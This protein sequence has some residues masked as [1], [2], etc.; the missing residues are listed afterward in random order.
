MNALFKHSNR[1]YDRTAALVTLLAV[2]AALPAS[3]ASINF[4]GA[5]DARLDNPANYSPSL[6]T[7]TVADS[8]CFTTTASPTYQTLT[9][10]ADWTSPAAILELGDFTFDLGA[11]HTLDMSNATESG[12]GIFVTGSKRFHLVSGRIY[13]P[14]RPFT[15]GRWDPNSAYAEITGPNTVLECKGIAVN[16]SN[17]ATSGKTYGIDITDGATVN[18]LGGDFKIFAGWRENVRIVDSVVTNFARFDMESRN[19][20]Y[21]P[22]GNDVLISGSRVIFN[23]TLVDI[24]S[25]ISNTTFT[26]SNGS[27]LEVPKIQFING[28]D[29]VFR[30]TGAG[31]EVY[32]SYN[33][34]NG[35]ARFAGVRNRMEISDGAI[36]RTTGG[37]NYASVCI[38][39]DSNWNC[40]AEAFEMIVTNG[41]SLLV[42]NASIFIAESN[43][44][45]NDLF[46]NRLVVSG[47]GSTAIAGL[48]IQIGGAYNNQALGK[49][50]VIYSNELVV[51]DGAVVSARSTSTGGLL[52]LPRQ[53]WG[54]RVLIDGGT[55]TGNY[56]ACMGEN[57]S[58]LVAS[59]NVVEIVGGGRFAL[60]NNN[61]TING[62]GNQFRVLDGTY[63][64]PTIY[65]L[66]TNGVVEIGTRGRIEAPTL[67]LGRPSNT[68]K[69]NLPREGISQPVF[70]G[71]LDI[72]PDCSLVL[73][74]ARHCAPGDYVLMETGIN[75]Y[76]QF[77]NAPTLDNLNAALDVEAPGSRVYVEGRNWTEG[78]TVK[79]MLHISARGTVL[80]LK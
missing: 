58:N 19:N 9:L 66:G 22:S 3:A 72:K 52:G 54:N 73:T 53:G 39:H 26:V 7:A 30:I 6:D 16:G 31:T 50:A 51:A 20:T 41:A 45:R 56:G 34:W 64:G 69:V 14:D 13:S 35:Y 18:G 68:L 4:T 47:P 2:M 44:T 40:G 23:T 15:I 49:Y 55:L 74:G 11:G 78:E 70:V 17:P 33:T 48:R 38:G 8:L 1:P 12:K 29:N 77:N 62:G 25:A 79:L 63:S 10:N 46:H 32:H 5:Q 59:N 71:N 60:T 67:N 36:F 57:T 61:F 27:Y 42:E 24:H 76:M 80:L 37:G 28:Y 21:Y 75:G 43:G 65:M